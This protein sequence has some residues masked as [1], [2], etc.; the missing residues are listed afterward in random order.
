MKIDRFDSS[1]CETVGDAAMAA[2]KTVAEEHGL[3][4]NKERGSRSRDGASYNFKV[5]FKTVGEGGA[6]SDFATSACFYGLPEDCWHAEL[7]MREGRCRIIGFNHKARKFKVM[8]EKV[9]GSRG[10]SYA[11]VDVRR[12]LELQ[13]LR[14]QAEKAQAS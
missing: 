8:T 14:A 11:T 4:I 9:D 1:T 7:D 13:A 10:Y 3:L 6:P 2:L 5:C 12:E